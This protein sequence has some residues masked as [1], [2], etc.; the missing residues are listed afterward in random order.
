MSRPPLAR[1]RV[2]DAFEAILIEEGERPATMDAT[3]RAAGVSKGGLL[4]HFGSKEA[5]EAGLIER[6][7][8]LAEI[9]VDELVA[10]PDGP[11]AAFLRTSMNTGTTLDRAITSVARLAQAGRPAAADALRGLRELWERMLRPHVTGETE[12]QL[13]ML[14]SDGL[15]FN[16]SLVGSVPGPVPTGADLAA[17]ITLVERT[18]RPR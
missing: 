6:M 14:V 5:L 12:L 11:V 15:Y 8:T 10:A 2:L 9:D 13:V 7:T 16:N 4:Y 17:L 1:D 3:A 18:A